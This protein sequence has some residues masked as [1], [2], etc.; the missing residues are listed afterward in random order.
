MAQVTSVYGLFPGPHSA[1]RGMNALR[2]A[3]VP[4]D[5]IVVMAPEP[6]EEYS[7]AQGEKKTAMGWIAVGGGLVG[8]FGGYMLAWYTQT[9]YPLVT[10]GMPIVAPW[11][12]GIVTYELT[13]MGAII[14]TLITLLVSSR[15]PNWSPKLYDPEVSHGKVLIGVVDPSDES[16]AGLEDRLRRAGAEKIK[17]TG[18]FATS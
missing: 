17:A 13:M 8:A 1:E 10:G 18:R 5:K 2:D 11:P 16:R 7:F 12:T 15:L 4:G 14:A 3:G 9:A 6:F